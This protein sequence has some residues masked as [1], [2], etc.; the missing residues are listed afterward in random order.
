MDYLSLL[1]WLCPGL[2]AAG[3]V[4]AIAGGGG[5]ICM[6]LYLMTGLPVRSVY[7]C[8]K[9]QYLSGCAATAWRYAKGG[10][11]DW[12]PALLGALGAA[13]GGLAGTRVVYLLTEGQIR[14][15]LL[16]LLPAAAVFSILVKNVWNHTALRCDLS[17]GRNRALLLGCGLTIGLYDSIVGPAGATV[18]MLLLSHFLKYD[19]RA[20]SANTRLVLMGSTLTA[21][22]IYLFNGDIVWQIAIPCALSNIAGGYVGAGLALKKGPGFVRFVAIGVVLAYVVKT[23][24]ERWL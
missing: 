16:V 21:F 24:A 1:W 4:D 18:S 19:I 7:G 22:C 3:L 12:R 5:L 8:N 13:V 10:Y 23:L 11:L 20:A 14:T 17:Q 6:P 15:M 2:F 9:F